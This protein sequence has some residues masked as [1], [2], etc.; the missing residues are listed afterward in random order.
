MS[1]AVEALNPLVGAQIR[2]D[3]AR[4]SEPEVIEALGDRVNF[5]RRVPGSNASAEDVYKVTLDIEVNDEPDYVLG[6]FFWHVDGV[7]MDM[8]LR[9][10][11]VQIRRTSPE[12]S[13]RSAEE[14]RGESYAPA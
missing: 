6:T 14:G 9:R 1:I 3:K 7:T 12:P 2:I 10:D 8:P 4:L 13:R 5:A 11:T